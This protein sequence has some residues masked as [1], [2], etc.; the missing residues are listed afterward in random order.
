MTT[1]YTP[2]LVRAMLRAGQD[3]LCPAVTRIDGRPRASARLEIV[4]YDSTCGAF[5]WT[6]AHLGLRT[7]SGSLDFNGFPTKHYDRFG[8]FVR[9]VGRRQVLRTSMNLLPWQE[10]NLKAASS[11]LEAGN[12]GDVQDL[13]ISWGVSMNEVDVE[14]RGPKGTTSE[15]WLP[16]LLDERNRRGRIVDGSP[17]ALA[18]EAAGLPLTATDEE[19]VVACQGNLEKAFLP[20]YLCKEVVSQAILVD[21]E[22]YENWTPVSLD[23][24]AA[25]GCWMPM[26]AFATREQEF[27]AKRDAAKRDRALRDTQ[28]YATK[29]AEVE[30]VLA[31]A[32]KIDNPGAEEAP[33]QSFSPEVTEEVTHQ[34][35]SAA[36]EA[37]QA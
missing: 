15:K 37:A 18:A 35:I 9:S 14:R 22:I 30:E 11:R 7:K 1:A 32:A 19:I 29:N 12:Y 26:A 36:T 24:L 34:E 23:S 31:A 33:E 2:A 13:M 8:G 21:L 16:R 25:Q 28:F 6:E 3:P 27:H 10:S 17:L 5:T 20:H 4:A